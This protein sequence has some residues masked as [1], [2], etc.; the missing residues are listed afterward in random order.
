[1]WTKGSRCES[2]ACVEVV[3]RKS[4]RSHLADACVEVADSGG[5]HVLVRQSTDPDGPVLTFTRGEWDAFVAGAKDGDFD[6]A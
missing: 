6:L 2:G 1:M 5:E 3:W 4:G